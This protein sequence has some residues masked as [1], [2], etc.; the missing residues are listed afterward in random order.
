MD[1]L[2]LDMDLLPAEVI[3]TPLFLFIMTFIDMIRPTIVV[4]NV[5]ISISRSV[6]HNFHIKERDM[7]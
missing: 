7:F 6:E 2:V 1:M 3:Q 5:T 4:N